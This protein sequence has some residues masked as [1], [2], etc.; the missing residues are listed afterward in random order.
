[1]NV[2]QLQTSLQELGCYM[3]PLD[4]KPGQLT[5][6]A[7]FAALTNGPDY[8][9]EVADAEE[10]AR[11]LRVDTASVWTLYDTE[12]SGQS[13]IEGRPAILFEPHRFSRA[14]GHR[15]DASNP[16]ISYRNWDR[17]KYPRSQQAR[18]D[19]LVEAVCLDVDAGFA[20]CSYGGFQILGENFKRCDA[21]SP[22][23]FAW[24]QA[25]TEADQLYAFIKFV[26]SDAVLLKAIRAKDWDKVAERY[27]GTGWRL[28]DYGNKLRHNYAKRLRP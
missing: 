26:S 5:K 10:A 21:V 13:F 2:L 7:I 22:W 4:G 25:Q 19:Q 1:M 9:L 27:N 28:N 18:Y 23:A 17:S 8:L 20:S 16:R 24:R 6:D 3:G 15:Y 12:S 14:T 11:E